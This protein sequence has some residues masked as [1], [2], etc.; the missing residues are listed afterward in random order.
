MRTAGDGRTQ[1]EDIT[2]EI[3]ENKD[4]GWSRSG[5]KC[6]VTEWIPRD[7]TSSIGRTLTRWRD[8]LRKFG[9]KNGLDQRSRSGWESM[10]E[11]FVLK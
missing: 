11:A 7:G 10:G 9:T 8:K 2:V 3:S 6:Q 1:G 5:T 4:F